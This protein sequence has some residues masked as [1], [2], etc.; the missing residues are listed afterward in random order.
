M[1]SAI[2]VAVTAAGTALAQG[3]PDSWKFGITIPVIIMGVD[4]DVTVRGVT[5]EVSLNF[6]DLKDHLEG[7][8][9]AGFDGVKNKVGFYSLISYYKLGEDGTT[10]LGIQTD[11][12]LK[13]TI[14]DA[15][16]SYRLV[17]TSGARPLIVEGI[18]GIRYWSTKT[19]L[20]ATGPGGSILA[21]GTHKRNLVDPIIG[22]RGVKILHP[23]WHVDFQGDIGGFGISDNSSDFDWSA[24]GLVSYEVGRHFSVG[25]GYKAFALDKSRGAAAD[26]NGLDIVLHGVLIAARFKF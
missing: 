7:Y 23:K 12:R 17:M 19:E 15:G 21:D 8:F 9:S 10:R 2:L 5:Q 25:G 1:L 11:A 22:L 24:S 3:Q 4:G 13:F 16:G 26:E 6:S 18:A 20:T 14:F